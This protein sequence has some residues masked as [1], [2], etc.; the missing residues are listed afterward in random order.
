MGATRE[1]RIRVAAA[2]GRVWSLV[3]DV[4]RMGEWSPE[5]VSCEWLDGVEGP[6]VGARFR[7]TNRRGRSKWATTCEVVAC[8]PAREFAFVTR[9]DKPETRWRYTFEPAAGGTEVVETFEILRPL[10]KLDRMVTRVT[11]G[12]KDREADM[13]EGMLVTLSRLREAAEAV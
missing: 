3:S 8:E 1:A 10:S 4:T 9:P 13:E 7:G 2:P 12:V 6:S 11:T 5:T